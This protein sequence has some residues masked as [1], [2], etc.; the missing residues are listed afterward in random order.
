M[1]QVPYYDIYQRLHHKKCL[2]G[3]L[4]KEETEQFNDAWRWTRKRTPLLKFYATEA[5]TQLSTKAIQVLG[6]YG[7]MCEYPL[8]KLH[9]D[10]FA[11]LL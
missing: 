11:L 3:E 5:F 2:H 9:R 6:G 8:E 1:I 4:T 10:S 7:Y